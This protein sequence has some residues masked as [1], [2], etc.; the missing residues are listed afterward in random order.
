MVH[1]SLSLLF[2]QEDIWFYE[3]AAQ[4]FGSGWVPHLFLSL[5]A[6]GFFLY[7]Y[8]RITSASQ[9][10]KMTPC[11][12]HMNQKQIAFFFFHLL[13]RQLHLT[14]TGVFFFTQSLLERVHFGARV[15]FSHLHLSSGADTKSSNPDTSCSDQ[16]VSRQRFK[17]V[18]KRKSA[19]NTF[20]I[21]LDIF[22]NQI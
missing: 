18:K 21:V 17:P 5:I 19:L 8:E 11:A 1:R 2:K 22:L 3:A 16:I 10:V 6:C 20:Q 13:F 14:I 12:P 7:T 4:S 9:I 15:Y